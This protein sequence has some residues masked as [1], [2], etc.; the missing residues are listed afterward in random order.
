[1]AMIADIFKCQ[2]INNTTKKS[3]ATGTL[4]TAGVEIAMDTKDVEGGGELVAVLHNGKKE[5]ITIEDVRFHF[6]I[7]SEQ[8]GTE[9]VTGAGVG[10]AFP[11]TYEITTSGSDKVI[12]LSHEPIT[13]TLALYKADGTLVPGTDYTATASV[14]IFTGTGYAVGDEIE[15]RTYQFTTDPLT[16]TIEINNKKFPKGNTVIL[17]TMEIDEDETP[18]N[19]IQI[20]FDNCIYDGSVKIDTKTARNASIHNMNMKVIKKVGKNAVGR[21]LRIPYVD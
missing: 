21:I 6:D 1:M 16:Q 8:L 9:I 11:E 7:L 10:Y 3:Y 13:G 4:S 17:Q 19:T 20:I 18:L 14:I 12:T 15:A 5:T 2:I